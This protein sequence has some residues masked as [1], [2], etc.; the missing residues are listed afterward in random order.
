MAAKLERWCNERPDMLAA[1]RQLREFGA[2][3]MPQQLTP[4]HLL[5]ELGA[6]LS[7]G[8]ERAQSAANRK[9]QLSIPFRCTTGKPFASISFGAG[10]DAPSPS[11]LL[12]LEPPQKDQEVHGIMYCEHRRGSSILSR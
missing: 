8:A 7:E 4:S 1:I 2:D 5:E 3:S 11:E 12:L 10:R 9:G 6:T